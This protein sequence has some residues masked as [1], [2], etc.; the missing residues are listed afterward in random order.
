M[1]QAAPN[2][3]RSIWAW[4]QAERLGVN[5]RSSEDQAALKQRSRTNLRRAL[6][7]LIWIVVAYTGGMFAEHLGAPAW[8]RIVF[9]LLV[10]PPMVAIGVHRMRQLAA[11]DELQQRVAMLA[12]AFTFTA[13]LCTLLALALL[14]DL[15]IDLPAPP[16]LWFWLYFL[17]DIVAA[18][19]FRW[20]Y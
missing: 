8:L 7:W 5:A 6:P 9:G 11:A 20:R 4:L 18:R 17:T 15:G 14:H 2:L 19:Y 1:P 3:L 16:L 12:M 13:A 10:V